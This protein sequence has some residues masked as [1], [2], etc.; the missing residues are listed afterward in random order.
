MAMAV[1]PPDPGS[2]GLSFACKGLRNLDTFSKSDPIVVIRQ[3]MRGVMVEIGRTETIEDDLNPIFKR[4][5][6][7][8]WNPPGVVELQFAVYDVDEEADALKNKDLIG[9]MDIKLGDIILADGMTVSKALK[10]LKGD[11]S[12]A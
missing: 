8:D 5:I 9:M 4:K 2:Y 11:E 12:T 10:G 3:K 1:L 6:Y 7:V